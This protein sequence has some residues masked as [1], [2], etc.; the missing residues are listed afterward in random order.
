[1]LHAVKS[2][3][4]ELNLPHIP[5]RRD[6]ELRAAKSLDDIFTVLACLDENLKIKCLPKYVLDSPD[7]MSSIR[8]YDGDL[9]RL[10]RYDTIRYIYVR[11]KADKRPA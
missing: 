8:I 7:S 6:G 9:L 2:L 5:S 4:S 10:I 3:E 11:S 1:M